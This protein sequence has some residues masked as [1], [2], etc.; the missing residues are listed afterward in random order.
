MIL[1]LNMNE[2]KS[3]FNAGLVLS[4]V[5]RAKKRNLT[6]QAAFTR[7]SAKS[8]I[9]RRRRTSAP[10]SPPS[11]HSGLLRKLIYF[12]YEPSTQSVVI[13]PMLTNQ[14]R[15]LSKYRLTQNKTVPETLETGGRVT[16]TSVRTG[17]TK[18]VYVQPRPFM[19][20][21]LIKGLADLEKY[22]KDTVK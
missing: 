9:R 22:W 14:A 5:D 19:R 2:L 4:A 12:I 17:R 16:R 1:T 6:K 8:S 21:A 18:R 15:K 11:S 3:R 20:P 7:R 10:G 13:G